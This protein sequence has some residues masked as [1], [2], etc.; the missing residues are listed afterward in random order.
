LEVRVSRFVTPP[1]RRV[2]TA[3]VVV[4]AA[5]ALLA[6]SAS[7]A[8]RPASVSAPPKA[9]KATAAEWRAL[10]AK[11]KQEGS[12]SI[13][14]VHSPTSL[15]NLA[16]KFKER[17]GIA[18]TINRKADNDLLPQ[19]NAEMSSGKLQVDVWDASAKRYVLGALKNGWV[20]DAVGPEFFKERYN[21]SKL[22][23]GKAWIDGAAILGMAWNT[24]GFPQ[25]VKDIP[26]FLNPAFA[27]GKLGVPDPRISPTQVD[28]YL[29]LEKTYGKGVIEKFAA[30]KPKIYSSSLTVTQ[31]VA[32]GEIIGGPEAAGS[33]IADL[34]AKGAPIDY[35]LAN[36][37]N[38]WN[39]AF[40]GM[41]LKK[42]P[43][44]AAAQLLANYMLTSEG[45]AIINQGLGSAY[46]KVPD[47]FYSPP[48]VARAN[49]LSPEK[50]KAFVDRWTKLFL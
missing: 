20:G 15:A 36:K 19:I 16:A 49:D 40:I 41:I 22:L 17:Y 32:S 24:Q 25:G 4:V 50:V 3:W 14:S 12:V 9:K 34:K 44:P 38:N 23:I 21:R 10:V 11:A 7:G 37:G 6:S 48:R 1:F 43:H 46:P 2:G 30:M 26:D 27:N 45:Q 33:P 35:K 47:T 8:H 39:S 13:Y 5:L 29:W 18:V 28:W 42:A 31:A